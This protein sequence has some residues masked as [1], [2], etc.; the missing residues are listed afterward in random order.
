M[1]DYLSAKYGLSG[2]ATLSMTGIIYTLKYMVPIEDIEGL[3]F[4]EDVINDLKAL[5]PPNKFSLFYKPKHV[6]DTVAR[7][8]LQ[9]AEEY[10]QCWCKEAGAGF[11]DN[12]LS[13]QVPAKPSHVISVPGSVPWAPHMLCLADMTSTFS[14]NW[15]QNNDCDVYDPFL[16]NPFDKTESALWSYSLAGSTTPKASSL[17][18]PGALEVS[19]ESVANVETWLDSLTASNQA[20]KTQTYTESSPPVDGPPY[21]ITLNSS[22]TFKASAVAYAGLSMQVQVSGTYAGL[23]Q[24]K[25]WNESTLYA[26]AAHY[27]DSDYN[28]TY[29]G[30]NPGYADM[31]FTHRS[32]I[33]APPRIKVRQFIVDK[34]ACTPFAD[35]VTAAGAI[36]RHYTDVQVLAPQQQSG[37]FQVTDVDKACVHFS[38]ESAIF[39]RHVSVEQSAVEPYNCLNVEDHQVD[40]A[41]F[42]IGLPGFV[43]LKQNNNAYL[44]EQRPS[45]YFIQADTLNKGTLANATTYAQLVTILNGIT[46]PVLADDGRSYFT[47]DNIYIRG[48]DAL[49][50][51]KLYEIDGR[52]Y[53]IAVALQPPWR[54]VNT[55]AS[56]YGVGIPGVAGQEW[57]TAT[58]V[59]FGASNAY[60]PYGIDGYFPAYCDA[61]CNLLQLTT[62]DNTA[63]LHAMRWSIDPYDADTNRRRSAIVTPAQYQFYS[64]YG[65]ASWSSDGVSSRNWTTTSG[66]TTLPL[67][68]ELQVWVPVTILQAVGLKAKNCP[69]LN[70]TGTYSLSLVDDFIAYTGLTPYAPGDSVGSSVGSHV[71]TASAS[72][73]SALMFSKRR[74]AGTMDASRAPT[75]GFTDWTFTDGSTI[76]I[77]FLASLPIGELP[78]TVLLKGRAPWSLQQFA[79]ER[80]E[81]TEGY[82]GNYM[83]GLQGATYRAL[84]VL[85]DVGQQEQIA[86]GLP[87]VRKSIDFTPLSIPYCIVATPIIDPVAAFPA[88][89]TIAAPAGYTWKQSGASGLT[90]ADI[91]YL[92]VMTRSFSTNSPTVTFSN[93][94]GPDGNWAQSVAVQDGATV[95]SGTVYRHYKKDAPG[96][97]VAEITPGKFD[98]KLL[99]ASYAYIAN[100][101][102]KLGRSAPSCRWTPMP[103]F[104]TRI[105][106]YPEAPSNRVVWASAIPASMPVMSGAIACTAS[107]NAAYNVSRTIVNGGSETSTLT[108]SSPGTLHLGAAYTMWQQMSV[109]KSENGSRDQAY[110]QTYTPIYDGPDI[111]GYD[112]NTVTFTCDYT[113][114]SS[115]VRP[116]N[117]Y[118]ALMDQSQFDPLPYTN[119]R[120][121]DWSAVAPLTTNGLTTSGPVKTYSVSFSGYPL[122]SP[123]PATVVASIR[124][125]EP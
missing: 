76:E 34:I 101:M 121:Q 75:F 60:A 72:G 43:L 70:L 37:S 27:D 95:G 80:A 97:G 78:S 30:L 15:S 88:Q 35:G 6:L 85:S 39:S 64:G 106:P 33:P 57:S 93:T 21:T 98:T 52:R 110:Q 40:A 50:Q 105:T 125:E 20:I 24:P 7:A 55:V 84:D 9:S 13:G 69:P 87:A 68:K 47:Q 11:W 53:V 90:S 25:F 91:P 19:V 38:P 4:F 119:T 116:V 51:W 12:W 8:Y 23:L 79:E 3:P 67:G 54:A 5:P 62:P 73:T 104:T 10:Y 118:A 111:I 71:V 86:S 26:E 94:N 28:F 31:R 44:L 96:T 59:S 120:E 48:T 109:T 100:D 107:E 83:Q 108:A 36:V 103:S 22:G 2:H 18:A 56:T 92:Y 114:V 65:Y 63:F 81:A 45:C 49:Y 66:A 29:F 89:Y 1:A 115:T 77:P 113:R 117:L 17:T 102:S 112:W 74:H 41:K 122:G 46:T 82:S 58:D 61:S 123:V 124:A 14:M 42:Q 99:D 32:S 16:N